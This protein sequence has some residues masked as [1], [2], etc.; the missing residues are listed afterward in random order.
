MKRFFIKGILFWFVLLI[1]AIL[2]AVVREATYKPILEPLIGNWAHQ[3]SSV[4]GILIFFIAILIFIKSV[5]KDYSK[6]DLIIIGII[7]IV[8][9][10]IFEVFMNVYIRNLSLIEVVETYYFWRGELWIFVLLSLVIS[11]LVA[12]RWI[13]K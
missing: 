7:W 6:K 8:M 3:I 13:R 4:I 9:T 5:K 10:I 2:N 12:D 11:P 1:L